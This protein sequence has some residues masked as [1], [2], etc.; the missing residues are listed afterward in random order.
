MLELALK[1][2]FMEARKKLYDLLINQGIAGEDIVKEIHRQI[3]DLETSE[4]EKIEI[5]EK[6][7][8]YE[9]RMNQGGE[10]MIQLEAL[11]AQI[12]AM[13]K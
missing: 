13:K 9:F 1:G 6:L 7:G 12:L 10:P 5:I 11:L 3:Y 8:E 4:E 2:K